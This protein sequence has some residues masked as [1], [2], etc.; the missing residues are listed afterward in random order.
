MV[1][2]NIFE[3]VLNKKNKDIAQVVA[4]AMNEKDPVTCRHGDHVAT[5]MAELA[6]VLQMTHKA[7]EDAYL[8]GLVHDV[9]KIAVPDY[10][11]T[12]P[13]KLTDQEFSIMKT[14]PAKGAELLDAVPGLKAMSSIA[15]Y[16]HERYD[17]HGY[18]EGLSGEDIP[19]LSRM[20]CV[21]DSYDAMTTFRGYREPISKTEALNEIASCSGKQFDPIISEV[22]ITYQRKG[23]Q[24]LQM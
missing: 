14:H 22:F 18:L 11:L 23:S 15:L 7:V 20:L 13:A 12:K 8:A 9:G 2:K 16:H 4:L 3:R 19:Y 6:T 24:S 1:N 5:L 21:C 17:G 10:I